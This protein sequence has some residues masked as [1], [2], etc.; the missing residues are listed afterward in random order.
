MD[1]KISSTTAPTVSKKVDEDWNN[2]LHD[3]IDISQ[4]K[5]E[6]NEPEVKPEEVIRQ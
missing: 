6:K 3:L 2:D 4:V 1:D 5:G